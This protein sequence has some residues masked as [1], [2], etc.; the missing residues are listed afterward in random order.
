M[1]KVRGVGD[2]T[3]ATL[4]AT[5]RLTGGLTRGLGQAVQTPLDQSSSGFNF[6]QPRRLTCEW[7]L[8]P[9]KGCFSGRRFPLLVSGCVPSPAVFRCAGLPVLL[10]APCMYCV[11]QPNLM[12]VQSSVLI[13]CS[14][15]IINLAHFGTCQRV[16]LDAAE[17]AAAGGLEA[18]PRDHGDI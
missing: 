12:M 2:T 3:A 16:A 7:V 1:A 15:T 5:L 14:A 11:V 10:P 13:H 6:T 8:A 4:G 17:R 18:W 9:L